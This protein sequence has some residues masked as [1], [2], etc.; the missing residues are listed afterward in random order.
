MTTMLARATGMTV[1]ELAA[2]FDNEPGY[3]SAATCGVAPRRAIDA[4][5][6]DEDSWRT[7]HAD[8]GA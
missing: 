3:L 8:P 5:R 6:S 4:M 1:A 7:G 2:E